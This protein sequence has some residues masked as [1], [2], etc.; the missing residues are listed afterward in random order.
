MKDFKTFQSPFSWRYGSDDMRNIWSEENKYKIW[1]KIWVE[2]ASAQKEFGLVSDEEL[3][4]LKSQQDNIDIERILEIEKDT[5]HDVVA[6]IREFAEKAKVGGGKIHLGATSMDIV[7]NTDSIRIKQSLEI[8]EKNLKTLIIAFADKI[9]THADTACMGFTHLQFAEPTTVGYRLSLYAQDLFEDLEYFKF[10][11]FHLRAKGFKGAVGT[12]ASYVKLLGEEKAA[13]MEQK[14][15]EQLGLEPIHIA[16]QVGPRKTD[17]WVAQ[18][19][20]SIAQSLYKFAFDVRILQSAGYGEW[21]EPFG[22]SQVGSSA[23]PFKKNPMKS[24][25][26]CSLARLVE[27]LS[28][29]AWENA[30]LSLLERTL[31][32]SGNR[33]V[34]I[35]EMFLAL[36]EMLISATSVISGLIIHQQQ[37]KNNLEKYGPFAASEAI[38]MEAVKKGADRQVMHEELRDIA[39][40]AWNDVSENKANPMEKLLKENES[41]KKS[42]P[43]NQIEALL[44][45]RQHVGSA[46]ERAKQLAAFLKKHLKN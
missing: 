34:Y 20:T 45:V 35:P 3:A 12:Q 6:A 8:I 43:E 16:N 21:Q 31:D 5:R 24:E 15:M 32:D 11:G 42:L 30:S 1:R 25:N 13:K 26:I 2:L 19:V 41:I 36:D 17:L 40:K 29:N 10:L 39:M 18:L 46:P 27:S 4:D 14:I 33:R 37:I 38:L 7:D 28:K 23:M 44:D 22:K 9:E